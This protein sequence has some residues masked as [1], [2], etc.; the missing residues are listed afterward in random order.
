M[1]TI[2]RHLGRLS[3]KLL[4]VIFWIPFAAIAIASFF[5]APS[6]GYVYSP[7]LSLA[8]YGTAVQAVGALLAIVA[9]GLFMMKLK[10]D[11]TVSN[12]EERTLGVLNNRLGW[13]AIRWSDDLE[14]HLE[15]ELVGAAYPDVGPV[16]A[17]GD[18]LEKELDELLDAILAKDSRGGQAQQEVVYQEARTTLSSDV[19]EVLGAMR[20]RRSL[21]ARRRDLIRVMGGPIAMLAV[22]VASAAWA[23]PASGG[24]L[25]AQANFNTALLFMETYG[26]VVA[27]LFT[28]VAALR[29]ALS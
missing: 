19:K 2:Q 22:L 8:T 6:L 9:A 12:L 4:N 26:G 25:V 10:I 1:R 23:L 28:V 15:E 20:E 18:Y 13:S 27:L 7:E 11:S 16:Q 17:S 29:V 14:E 3:P 21:L 5:M 24:F